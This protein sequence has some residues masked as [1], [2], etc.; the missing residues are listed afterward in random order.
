MFLLK[1]LYSVKLIRMSRVVDIL[2]IRNVKVLDP[3][4]G[5]RQWE[6]KAKMI[7]W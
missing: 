3:K 4:K 1:L 7:K 5:S 6:L 2:L